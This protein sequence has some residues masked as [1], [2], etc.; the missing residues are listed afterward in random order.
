MLDLLIPFAALRGGMGRTRGILKIAEKLA[1]FGKSVL[2]V[3]M[4]LT[5]PTVAT[6]LGAEERLGVANFFLEHPPRVADLISKAPSGFSVIPAGS[7]SAVRRV[8]SRAGGLGSLKQMREFLNAIRGLQWDFILVDLPPGNVA[9]HWST[10]K[11]VIRDHASAVCIFMGLGNEHD[12]FRRQVERLVYS[13]PNVRQCDVLCVAALVTEDADLTLSHLRETGGAE[14]LMG[15]IPRMTALELPQSPAWGDLRFTSPYKRLAYM[16]LDWASLRG[17]RLSESRLQ[18]A[19]TALER[20]LH[21]PPTILSSRLETYFNPRIMILGGRKGAGKTALA[22]SARIH[23]LETLRPDPNSL[24]KL[25]QNEPGGNPYRYWRSYFSAL[26]LYPVQVI[27]DGLDEAASIRFGWES[28][29]PLIEGLIKAGQN[30]K[31]LRGIDFDLKILLLPGTV[32]ALGGA[33]GLRTR[34]IRFLRWT[35]ADLLQ[36]ALRRAIEAY[37]AFG[38]QLQVRWEHR[39][40]DSGRLH[41][42]WS[43]SELESVAT[44]FFGLNGLY[45]WERILP[46]GWSPE[47]ELVP[48]EAAELLLHAMRQTKSDVS[49]GEY[50]APSTLLDALPDFAAQRYRALMGK[51]KFPNEAEYVLESIAQGTQPVTPQDKTVVELLNWGLLSWEDS[52]ANQLTVPPLV[53]TGWYK[54]RRTLSRLPTPVLKGS[55]VSPKNQQYQTFWEGLLARLRL[56]DPDVAPK[57]VGPPRYYMTTSAGKPGTQLNW[58]FSPDGLFR[59][60]LFIQHRKDWYWQLW[61]SKGELE[62]AL[63]P[64]EWE[65]LENKQASRISIVRPGSIAD[66]SNWPSLHEWGVEQYMR[67]RSTLTPR[68]QSLS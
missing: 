30:E 64:L 21:L 54:N 3:D 6:D 45:E 58:A 26:P 35:K 17:N 43:R 41:A 52:Q 34:Q 28:T 38:E 23:G 7:P 12:D 53:M 5:A 48:G 42:D 40:S 57:Q 66:K 39:V 2:V 55:E 67:M 56:N 27:I 61:Q 60:E 29:L 47:C 22:D 59:V 49:G 19:V 25:W 65:P 68:L 51:V 36:M 24:L 15:S 13:R 31:D 46:P 4:D 20:S 37:P 18:V 44:A 14:R 9:L 63:G 50:I 16:F 11:A 10:V 62:A 32:A 33:Q 1:D 8:L